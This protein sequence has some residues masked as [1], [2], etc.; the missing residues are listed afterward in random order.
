MAVRL[1]SKFAFEKKGISL[2]S[3]DIIEELAHVFKACHQI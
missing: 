3:P 2:V 1:A